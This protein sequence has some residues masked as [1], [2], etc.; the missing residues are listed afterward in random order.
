MQYLPGL[1]LPAVLHLPVL[2]IASRQFKSMGFLKDYIFPVNESYPVTL[3][4]GV[5]AMT[6]FP[7]NFCSS[8]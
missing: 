6:L 2:N 1:P 8:L 7:D 5:M 4:A 3:L